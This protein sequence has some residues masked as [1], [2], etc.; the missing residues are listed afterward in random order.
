MLADANALL[1]KPVLLLLVLLIGGLVGVAV[2][3]VTARSLRKKRAAFWR[4]ANA[5]KRTTGKVIAIGGQHGAVTDFAADQLKAV[6]QA[7]F[8]A[9]PVLNKPE[10]RLLECIDK[11]LAELSPG[12]RAM[13]QVSLGEIL[14]S[15]SKEAF[16]AI[17]S[18]RVDLLIVDAEC[19]PL[20]AVEFQ[21]TGHHLGPETAARDAV[22][23]E[24]LRRAGI[25]FVEVPS[26]DTPGEVR[27][28]V[29]KLVG[30]SEASSATKL[31]KTAAQSN[32]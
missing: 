22:K 11:A 3:R 18:K 12:W 17:N 28:L 5:G 27:E 1:D 24:A 13:A 2:E 7:R 6:M 10:R 32:N 9:Q 29:R 16:M 8:T 14:R 20:H 30:R 4:G 15:E 25:S 26:G 19:R 21:G 23:R 31:P